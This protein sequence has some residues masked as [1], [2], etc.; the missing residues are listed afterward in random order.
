MGY[1][2]NMDKYSV[3]ALENLTKS[4][5]KQMRK[6]YS[7]LRDIA[8]KRIKRLGESEYNWA[9]AYT[10]HSSGFKKLAEIEPE[11]F[12]KEMS[13]L[14]KFVNA[15]LSTVSGQK[16]KREAIKSSWREQGLD[17]TNDNYKQL[18]QIIDAMRNLKVMYGSDKA[19]ALAVFVS[20]EGIDINIVLEPDKLEKLLLHADELQ[21]LKNVADKDNDGNIESDELAVNM[22]KYLEKLGW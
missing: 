14:A 8:Q 4:E 16:A 2:D 11:N 20:K 21:N 15:K 12:A 10:S 22:D 7:R 9:K 18:F 19:V 17:V 5:L 1:L 13:Q 6:E 3:P